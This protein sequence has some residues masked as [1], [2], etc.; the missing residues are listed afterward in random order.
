MK[1]SEIITENYDRITEVMTENYRSVIEANGQIQY[2]VYIWEDGEIELL[3][4]V[5]GDTS[6]LRPRD[7]ESRELYYITTIEAPCFNPWD[8]TDHYAPDD[9]DECEAERDEIIDYL[10]REYAANVSDVLD[11]IIEDAERDER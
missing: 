6:Y 10:V 8:Y 9:E 1:R 4:G 11:A 3:Y 7:T 2:K 5:Q